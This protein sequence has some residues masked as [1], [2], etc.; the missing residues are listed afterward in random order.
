MQS[1][2]SAPGKIILFG[3]H[4]VVYGY[5][6]VALAINMHSFCIIRPRS[7][8]NCICFLRNFGLKQELTLGSSEIQKF[9]PLF[10][11]IYHDLQFFI[12]NFGIHID[13][14]SIELVSNLLPSAGLG[15]SASISTVLLAALADYY[16]IQLTP[17]IF[18]PLV[19]ECEKH[20][21]GNPS[22][23]DN[24]ICISGG[25]IRFQKG[26]IKYLHI[27]Q[28]IPLLIIYS[29][30]Q[31]S[32][33]NAITAVRRRLEQ[34]PN[35]ITNLFQ[36]I[37]QIADAGSNALYKGDLNLLS[38]L[39]A[40]NQLLLTQ[41]GLTTVNI[42]Q[43]IDLAHSLDINGIKITGAGAGG[44]LIAIAP[45]SRLTQLREKLTALGYLSF[46]TQIDPFGVL[47]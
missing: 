34:S 16:H 24:T 21:H 40:Q 38:Q 27:P 23:I 15:S 25:I 36:K 7:G 13:K 39:M 19:F 43:I 29:G 18:I 31:H 11:P 8:N 45:I 3:E 9:N 22:G 6:A 30:Q 12:H 47:S 17:Q 44:C 42:T 41:L 20:V 14:I 33:Q 37:G 10:Y 46:M 1:I 35:E 5:P 26:M 2:A 4:A 28:S 32:T